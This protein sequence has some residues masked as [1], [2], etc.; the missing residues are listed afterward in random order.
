MPVVD[1][2]AYAAW[3]NMSLTPPNSAAHKAAVKQALLQEVP[4]VVLDE[5]TALTLSVGY[6]YN[7]SPAARRAFAQG[8][9]DRLNQ[10][11]HVVY[12]PNAPDFTLTADGDATCHYWFQGGVRIC[13]YTY[14][15]LLGGEVWEVDDP[16]NTAPDA[17][18]RL[19]LSWQAPLSAPY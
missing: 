16:G 2:E 3:F 13:Y 7:V 12:G 14:G 1:V 17:V 11:R 5:W 15:L 8:L 19:G 6:D 9:I 4:Q 10:A 18:L